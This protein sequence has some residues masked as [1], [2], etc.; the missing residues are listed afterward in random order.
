LLH[1]CNGHALFRLKLLIR[2]SFLHVR[3]LHE[4]GVALQI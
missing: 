2:S 1:T 4:E 3:T